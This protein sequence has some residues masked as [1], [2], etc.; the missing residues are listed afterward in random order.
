MFIPAGPILFLMS[1]IKNGT[2][3][4]TMGNL[5]LTRQTLY[6]ISLI[7]YAADLISTALETLH[8]LLIS[9]FILL[10]SGTA[11]AVEPSTPIG[12]IFI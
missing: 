6:L 4:I 2:D 3:L 8:I 7:N 9:M 11:V 10:H 12:K 1:S 5:A